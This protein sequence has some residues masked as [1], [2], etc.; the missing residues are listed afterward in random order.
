MEREMS[1]HRQEDVASDG[2]VLQSATFSTFAISAGYVTWLIRAG[3]LSGSLL[4]FA[5]M[6]LQI[7][8]LPVLSA[9]ARQRDKDQVEAADDDATEKRLFKLFERSNKNKHNRL[10]NPGVKS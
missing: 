3:A 8:P 9:R 7:D 1:E 4:S 2:L 6:W 10:I 5:P